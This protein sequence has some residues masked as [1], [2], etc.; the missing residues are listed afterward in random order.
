MWVF[1]CPVWDGNGQGRKLVHRVGGTKN[2]GAIKET[3][4]EIRSRNMCA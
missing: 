4:S 2:K 3:E 1:L